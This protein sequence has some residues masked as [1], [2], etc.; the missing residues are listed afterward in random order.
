MEHESLLEKV[1]AE[2][3]DSTPL[4]KKNSMLFHC[5][6]AIADNINTHVGTDQKGYQDWY[7]TLR[8][9]FMR[10]AQKAAVA[11]ID[12]KW[13]HWKAEQIDKLATDEK[14]NLANC[15]REVAVPTSVV[16]RKRTV[17]DSLSLAVTPQERA[18]LCPLAIPYEWS[19]TSHL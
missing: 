15:A 1:W 13:L 12:E 6:T 7:L 4:I 3:V 9:N 16:D 18:S 14:C 17:S 19:M 11:N 5:L 10:K 8:N 2:I